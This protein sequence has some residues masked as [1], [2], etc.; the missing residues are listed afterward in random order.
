[1]SAK[2]WVFSDLENVVKNRGA[3]CLSLALLTRIVREATAVFEAQ[4]GAIVPETQPP[5][6]TNG[7]TKLVAELHFDTIKLAWGHPVVGV[8]IEQDTNRF[9][10]RIGGADGTAALGYTLKEFG[11]TDETPAELFPALFSCV[12]ESI[13]TNTALK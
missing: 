7:V 6:Q 1:M 4:N 2:T 11:W 9:K 5:T 10:V 3:A 8:R 12:L 13:R